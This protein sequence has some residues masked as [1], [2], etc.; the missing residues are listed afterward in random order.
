[1]LTL[2]GTSANRGMGAVALIV[3]IL[4]TGAKFPLTVAGTPKVRAGM[5][6]AGLDA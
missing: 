1:M 2:M 6:E 3:A 5:F 4:L